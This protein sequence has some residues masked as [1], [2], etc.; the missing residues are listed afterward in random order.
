M[1]SVF[2]SFAQGLLLRNE[3]LFFSFLRSQAKAGREIGFLQGGGFHNDLKAQKMRELRPTD[4]NNPQ[5][6]FEVG[7]ALVCFEEMTG[8]TLGYGPY[9]SHIL[10][11]EKW[12]RI[13]LLCFERAARLQYAPAQLKLAQ[14]FSVGWTSVSSPVPGHYEESLIVMRNLSAHREWLFKAAENGDSNA[15][16]QLA[17]LFNKEGK[18]QAAISWYLLSAEKGEVSAQNK[19]ACMYARGE[20]VPK[21]M[22]QAK[23]WWFKAAEQNSPIAQV[24]VGDLFRDGVTVPKNVETAKLW[25]RR[26]A[27]LGSAEAKKNLAKLDGCG[28][29]VGEGGCGQ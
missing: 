9:G 5:K 24:T 1:V 18:H 27:A 28:D 4:F 19:L 2:K 13:A 16:A 14:V 10:V 29:A 25:Y 22:E 6:L 8:E 21:D 26:A 7:K 12:G 11:D 20:G 3:R 23:N 17:Y 15:Q